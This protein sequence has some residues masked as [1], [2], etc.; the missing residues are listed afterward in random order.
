MDAVHRMS[1]DEYAN[2]G[3]VTHAAGRAVAEQVAVAIANLA[4][5]LH[6]SPDE[7]VMTSGATE[8][9]NLALMGVCLHPRQKRRRIVSTQTEHRAV[10]D[11]LERLQKIGFEVCLLPVFPQGHPQC[12]QIDL[13][14]ARDKIDE[15]TALVSV[16]LANNEIG[17]IQPI[18]DIVKLCRRWDVP[19]HSD[20][21]QAIGHFDV[22]VDQLDVDLMSFSGHKFYGPKGVGG[23]FVRHRERRVKLSPQIVGGG[24]QDNRRSGTLNSPGIVGMSVALDICSRH[25]ESERPNIER[26]RNQLWAMIETA[27]RGEV[28]LNGPALDSP[29]RL[30]RNL[31]CHWNHVEGQS[32]MLACPDLCISSG[33]ACTSA[34]PAP[35]HVLQAIGL[36]VEQARCSLRFGLGRFN[37]PHEIESAAAVLVD[38]YKKLRLLNNTIQ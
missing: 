20:A 8:S 3:S 5:H 23:L 10:L 24:Q 35:S 14:Q 7:L 33:S 38:A 22:D 30:T 21:T 17:V 11:P 37:E 31:N 15:S 18:S 13:D 1:A 34:N 28:T 36:S 27:T 12:G 16:L 26:M 25:A 9:N 19:L 4:K 6:A 29:S 32:L 2:S